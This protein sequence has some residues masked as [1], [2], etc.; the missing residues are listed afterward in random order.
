MPKEKSPRGPPGENEG[1]ARHLPAPTNTLRAL[2]ALKP[3]A[4]YLV[5][6]RKPRR[7]FE[8]FFAL[9]E[10]G[11]P[12]ICISR[13]HPEQL[14]KMHPARFSMKWLSQDEATEHSLRPT[15]PGVLLSTLYEFMEKNRESTVLLDGLEYLVTNNTF[16]SILKSVDALQEAVVL[17][18]AI[19]LLPVDP[20][21]FDPK[22]MALLERNMR[23]LNL[24][25][26]RRPGDTDPETEWLSLALKPLKGNSPELEDE[27]E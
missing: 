1:E 18:R 23:V 21:A 2:R 19:L 26:R 17:H 9:I 7:T 20:Q 15:N 8:M 13:V 3:G 11:H 25:G 5:K 14:R 24:Q 16:N 12:A 27:E 22:E 4:T 6:E 10:A